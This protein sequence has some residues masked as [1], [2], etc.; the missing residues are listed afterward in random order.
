MIELQRLG[1]ETI[2]GDRYADAPAMQVAHRSHVFRMLDGAEL[3]RVVALEQ[4]HLIVPEI[5]AIDTAT[6]L[7][8]EAEG[9]RVVP[10]ARDA[11]DHGLWRA[12]G[13]W[14][15][16]RSGCRPR[17]IVS[18]PT[19]AVERAEGLPLDRQVG[20]NPALAAL[21]PAF[22]AGDLGVV[23]GLGDPDFQPVSLSRDRHLGHGFIMRGNYRQLYNGV[24]GRWWN[25][26]SAQFEPAR[27]PPLPL[28]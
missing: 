2:A 7:A 18:R 6:L 28:V 23:Q 9:R 25:C 21:M 22:E 26:Q 24:L 20:L 17:P 14:P 15:R 27:Y 4:P 13:A 16:R 3:R 1:V 5:E 12:S 10:T 19:L 8:L 11:A